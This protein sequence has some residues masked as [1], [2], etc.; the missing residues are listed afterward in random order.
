MNRERTQM[1]D[2]RNV[3][4]GTTL[5][6]D[7]RSRVLTKSFNPVPRTVAQSKTMPTR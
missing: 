6:P 7:Y 5:G 4:K 2:V 3:Y 1:Y